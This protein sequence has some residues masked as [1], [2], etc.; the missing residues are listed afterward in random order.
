MRIG[1]LAVACSLSG[2][3]SSLVPLLDNGG[4]PVTLTPSR[5]IPLEIITHKNSSVAD[6]LPVRGTHIEFGDVEA[7]LG[8]AVASATVPWAEAHRAIRPDGW[9]LQ[10]DLISADAEAS[11]ESITI[12]LGVRATLRT[13]VGNRYIAQTQAHCKRTGAVDPRGAAPIVFD[14]MAR[15]GRE[16]GGW[17][18]SPQISEGL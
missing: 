9:Q 10:V 4:V 16:L 12:A 2:C 15:V 14:C 18:G 13:R 11:G 5:D 3:A 8:H 1:V 7:A 17:L 6:P